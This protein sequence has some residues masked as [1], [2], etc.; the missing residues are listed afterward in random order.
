MT[1]A[2]LIS[3]DITSATA[4]FFNIMDIDVE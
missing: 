1:L 2:E 4:F 3:S